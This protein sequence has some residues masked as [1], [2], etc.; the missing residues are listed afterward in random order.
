MRLG[1]C[2]CKDI[3]LGYE[4]EEVVTD[5]NFCY[6]M[7]NFKKRMLDERMLQKWIVG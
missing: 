5:F 4:K 2:Q 1:R 6:S 7:E 3:T